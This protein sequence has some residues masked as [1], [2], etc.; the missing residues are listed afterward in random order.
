MTARVVMRLDYVDETNVSVTGGS[1]G[2]ALSIA[3]AS[4]VP[5]IKR[6]AACYPF[7]CDYRRVWN[8][9]MSI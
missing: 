2:G 1:Q 4:L 9:D 8:M 6:V 5:E 7:L 3:C